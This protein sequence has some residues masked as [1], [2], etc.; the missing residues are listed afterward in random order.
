MGAINCKIRVQEPTFI[1]TIKYFPTI[2]YIFL[3][4]F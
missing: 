4:D 2:N 3:T 1:Y